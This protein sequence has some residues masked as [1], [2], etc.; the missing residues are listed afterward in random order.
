MAIKG[1]FWT[2]TCLL[3]LS[4]TGMGATA[5]ANE[6]QLSSLS[7]P[8]A[9]SLA[10]L[11]RLANERLPSRLATIREND[12][13]CV[14]SKWLK[15][16]IPFT[17]EWLKTKVTPAIKC[18]IVGYVDRR[19]N[20]SVSGNEHSI[21]ISIPLHASIS[22]RDI[23]GVIASE[24][25]TA[26]VTIFVTGTPG[27]DSDWNPVL[28]LETDF[29][30]DNRPTLELF[31]FVDVTIGSKVEPRLRERLE[32]L[33][34][35]VGEML[36]A[37]GVRERVAKAWREIQDPVRLSESPEAYLLFRP[38]RVGFS[39]IQ[40]AENRLRTYV[41]V[42]GNTNVVIGPKPSVEPV[43]LQPVEL[44]DGADP[45]FS[46]NVPVFIHEEEL[47][48]TVDDR[49]GDGITVDVPS[50][51]FRASEFT[52]SLSGDQGIRAFAEVELESTKSW[53]NVIDVFDWMSFSGTAE[54]TL[55]VELDGEDN[56]VRAK[57]FRLDSDTNSDLADALVD[58]LDL[59]IVRRSL[60]HL[61]Q[62]DYAE[63]ASAA[64]VAAND[65]LNRSSSEGVDISGA[66]DRVGAAKLEVRDELLLLQV[67][68]SGAVVVDVKD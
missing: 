1:A 39:G 25:A 55:E 21:T 66:M 61:L 33:E 52:I 22:A 4:A 27:L 64:M 54:I 42:E 43:Q 58:V 24:T 50:G 51:A 9:V 16:R 57:S 41:G 37:L 8:I 2:A 29:R 18:D 10:K 65:A 34:D 11:E 31:G 46:L 56:L 12:R 53:L 7:M 26:D 48:N 45:G 13:V 35:E 49:L 28:E 47:Q 15:T 6:T 63:L 3:M 59:P 62:Y 17:G 67:F 38:A 68:G 14:E 5:F 36:P 40:I 20:L 19:G 23:G 60:V 44:I 30:W 32:R